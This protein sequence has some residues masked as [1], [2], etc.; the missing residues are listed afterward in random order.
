M[1][2]IGATVEG[3]GVVTRPREV[4]EDN[5]V[6]VTVRAISRTFRFVPDIRTL[7]TLERAF[8]SIA[9]D[10]EDS[11]EI[12]EFLFMSNHFHMM[13]TDVHGLLPDFMRDLNSYLARALN[14]DRG[15]RGSNIEKGHNVV[16]IEDDDAGVS[17]AVY[18]L[19]NPPAADLVER[20]EDWRGLSSLDMEYGDVRVSHRPDHGLWRARP[21][22]RAGKAAG[23]SGRA[24]YMGRSKY[25]ETVRLRLVRPPIHPE[26]S[27]RELRALIRKRLE[28]KVEMLRR[29][30]GNRSVLGWDRVIKQSF[31]ATPETSEELFGKAPVVAARSQWAKRE[32][33]QCNR[34]FVAEYEEA[35]DRHCAGD[36]EAE[37]PYGTWLMRRRYTKVRCRPRPPD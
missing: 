3:V 21:K 7:E 35:R 2:R 14:A 26:L 8:F 11:I 36:H 17:L 34:Q 32:A 30:R 25:G 9:Q 24:H 19:A 16:R 12:H 31:M 15:T 13:L 33:E 27:D 20:A 5:T 10:Y 4:R 28:A 29:E 6:F 1:Q 23:E 18:T 22:E 37:F